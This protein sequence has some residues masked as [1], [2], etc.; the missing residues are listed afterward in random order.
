MVTFL[1]TISF[2]LSVV[3]LL[4]VVGAGTLANRHEARIKELED[5]RNNLQAISN[6]I[7]EIIKIHNQKQKQTDEKWN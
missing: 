4:L 6:N 5:F 1:T 7:K 2:C 3:A